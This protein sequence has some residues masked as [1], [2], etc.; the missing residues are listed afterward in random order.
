MTQVARAT[1]PHGGRNDTTSDGRVSSARHRDSG[2]HHISEGSGTAQHRIMLVDD[3]EDV[4]EAVSSA[5]TEA[6]YDVVV[7][8]EGAEALDAL[9]NSSAPHL[10]LLDL[11]MPRMTGVEFRRRLL[12]EMPRLSAVPVVVM[13]ADVEGREKARTLGA[14]VFLRKPIRLGELFRHVSAHLR[15]RDAEPGA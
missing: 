3:D 11:T 14:A 7:A 12:A 4:R 10:I 8:R 5:L 2:T 9:R 6:G 13:S 1:A 15:H